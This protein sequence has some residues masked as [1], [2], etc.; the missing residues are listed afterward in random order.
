MRLN[1]L[2]LTCFACT[3]ATSGCRSRRET[4]IDTVLDHKLVREQGP[5]VP[6]GDRAT[7]RP[8]VQPDG[9]TVLS[10]DWRP[11]C[12]VREVEQRTIQTDVERGVPGDRLA[13]E[14]ALA[15]GG[16]TGFVWGLAIMDE[17][18]GGAGPAVGAIML[19]GLVTFFVW[20]GALLSDVSYLMTTPEGSVHTQTRPH[21]PWATSE[22]VSWPPP[23]VA[24]AFPGATVQAVL[25]E[26]KAQFKIEPWMWDQNDGVIDA[27]VRINGRPSGHVRLVHPD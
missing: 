2:L 16:A 5:R 18:L 26:G 15:V 9:S 27:E 14:G 12:R 4:R 19:G 8:E 17:D 7:L 21:G 23:H 6:S 1:R 20:G 22:C 11:A 25:E 3:L 13:V 10:V 24:L